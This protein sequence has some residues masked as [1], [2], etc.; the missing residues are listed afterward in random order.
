MKRRRSFRNG[1]E[2]SHESSPQVWRQTTPQYLKNP[3][4]SMSRRMAA[5]VEANRGHTEYQSVWI[6]EICFNLVNK[7]IYMLIVSIPQFLDASSHLYKRVCPS[8]GPSVRRLV[9]LS[10][11]NA[12]FFKLQKRRFLFMYVT[13][14]AREHHR[15]VE[16]HLCRKVFLLV[17]PSIFEL[18]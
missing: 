12:F 1:K 2:K 14:E 3:Y 6:H 15:N 4:Q 5:V 17:R 10:V 8:V 18:S 7:L 9:C 16:L 13:R 11:R